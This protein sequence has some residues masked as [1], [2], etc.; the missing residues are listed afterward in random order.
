MVLQARSS[1]VVVH[2]TDASDLE[3][4]CLRLQAD[5]QGGCDP[6]LAEGIVDGALVAQLC[7]S[8]SGPVFCNVIGGGQVP[9]ASQADLAVLG[10]QE[11]IDSPT[12]LF[13][14]Q[15]AIEQA[16]HQL[17]QEHASPGDALAAPRDLAHCRDGLETNLRR[18]AG[19]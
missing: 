4:I 6:L 1:P 11:L 8:A 15:G 14:A 2:R 5:G 16:L 10:V 17:S 9:T 18:T 3:E 19:A 13:A 7:R 12:C